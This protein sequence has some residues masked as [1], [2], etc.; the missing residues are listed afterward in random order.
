[1]KKA[2]I[3]SAVIVV[4]LIG[5][6]PEENRK[7]LKA[8]NRSMEFANEALNDANT[9]GYEDLMAG[10]PDVNIAVYTEKWKIKSKRI[11]SFADSV[12]GLLKIIKSDLIK[13]SDGLKKEHVPVV[14]QL[15][16]IN[17][18]GNQLL[19][20][21]I[22]FKDS[23]PVVIY[24]GEDTVTRSYFIS[25]FKRYLK[26]APLLPQ[27]EDNLSVDQQ[28]NY[29]KKWL[30]GS[31]GSNSTLMVMIALNKVESDVLT[32]EKHFIDY[33]Q[34][35]HSRGFV[36]TYSMFRVIA[37]LSSSYVKA[38]QPIDVYAGVGS[39]TVVSKGRITIDGKEVALDAEGV[40]EYKFVATGKPGR[41]S[42]PVTIEFTKVDGSK[43]TVS[44]N[45]KYII[46]E[47]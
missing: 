31:F 4:L 7:Q 29:K 44:K 3:I 20:K 28:Y 18:L 23:C 6:R 40:A 47:N 42:V 1:M 33:C 38:G 26:T 46:A 24:S 37:T 30:E 17:G 9:L 12:K 45:A 39:F 32:S 22:S 36:E 13:Q 43:Q 11:K 35:R 34:S 19:N 16:D 41:H 15:N 5:C 8:I 14:K 25:D 21:L 27:Y 2:L 10:E